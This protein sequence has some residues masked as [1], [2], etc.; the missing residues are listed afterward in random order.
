MMKCTT[1]RV[2]AELSTTATSAKRLTL[3]GWNGKPAKLDL[4]VWRTD[5]NELK[6]GKGIT[7]TDAEA[8]TLANAL[9]DYLAGKEPD[10]VAE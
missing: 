3:T 8:R 9:E 10:T 1:E 5:E 4:R 6:A 2:L 7:L